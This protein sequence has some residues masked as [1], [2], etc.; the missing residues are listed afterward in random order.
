MLTVLTDARRPRPWASSPG[1]SSCPS[2]CS[3][4]GPGMIADR[5]PQAPHPARHPDGL[6]A[7][8]SLLLGVLAV[9]GTAELWQVYAIALFPGVATAVDNPARQAFVSEM[10]PERPAH[11]RRCPQ[12]RVVQRGP[13]HR[14]G[15]GRRLIIAAWAPA[16]ALLL[17]TLTFVAVIVALLRLRHPRAAPRAAVTRGKRRASARACATC[18]T[19][20]TSMLVMAAGVRARHVRHELPDHHGADGDQ[21]VRQGAAASTACS[22]RS[23]P[24][25]R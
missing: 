14:P 6:L 8:S 3:R 16:S 17:N 19:A 18:G 5:F 22:A 21:G 4:R 13:P 1:C 10:V 23:W 24:S 11:Q 15:P 9:T 20:P 25:A 2:C 7:L 12:Q